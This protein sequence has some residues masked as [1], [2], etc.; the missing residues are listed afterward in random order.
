MPLQKQYQMGYNAVESALLINNGGQ[1]KL[2]FF[3][4]GVA[5]LNKDTMNSDEIMEIIK[6]NKGE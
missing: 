5:V 1:E 6:N 2:K 4:T 3:D